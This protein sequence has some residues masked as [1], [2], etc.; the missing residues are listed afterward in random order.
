MSLIEF[1]ITDTN[2]VTIDQETYFLLEHE[3]NR[4][5]LIRDRC[6]HRGAPLRL[7]YIDADSK[8]LVCPGHKNSHCLARL[9]QTSLPIIVYSTE[10]KI[11]VVLS[12]GKAPSVTSSKRFLPY[13]SSYQRNIPCK[14]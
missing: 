11:V 5:A 2:F 3:P 1:K 9:F 7:G 12:C 13:L 10:K 14:L 6:A 8:T 4:Y